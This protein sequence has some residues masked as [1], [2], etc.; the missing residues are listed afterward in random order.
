M[1]HD[2]GPIHQHSSYHLST[3][4]LA[5]ILPYLNK[6]YGM[7]AD[8][9]KR[10]LS[11]CRLLN[12]SSKFLPFLSKVVDIVSKPNV[13]YNMHVNIQEN[14]RYG[15]FNISISVEKTNGNTRIRIPTNK[16]R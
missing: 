12:K 2:F 10:F 14:G 1:N 7:T 16:R 5:D 9:A 13:K 15:I 11:E 8:G 6:D 4:T 3:E